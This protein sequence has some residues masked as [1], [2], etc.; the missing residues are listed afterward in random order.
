MVARRTKRGP[1]EGL[2]KYYETI[3]WLE[4]KTRNIGTKRGAATFISTE[5]LTAGLDVEDR[6]D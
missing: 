6:N 4:R 1:K 3:G 5:D 2:A